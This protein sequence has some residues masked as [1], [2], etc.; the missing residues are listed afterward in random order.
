MLK[1]DIQMFAEGKVIIEADLDTKGFDKEIALLERK[2]E[3][4]K[5]T[6]VMADEDK[7]LFSKQEVMEMEAEAQKLGRQIDRLKKKQKELDE[8]G[9]NN[10]KK[11]IEDV[12]NLLKGVIT[13]VGK[14]GL[15]LFGIRSAYS[16]IRS[17][18][19][20]IASEDEQLATD[21]EYMKWV[22]AQTIKPVVEWIVNALYTALRLINAIT[23]A[24]FNFDILAG[25][26]AEAFKNSKK[27][28]GGMSSALKEAKKQL[29]GFD[30]MNVLQ[31]TSTSG[32]G[33]GGGVSLDWDM[34]DIEQKTQQFKQSIETLK[35]SWMTFGEEM[36]YSIEEMP[37]DKWT[38]GFG[39]WDL[40]IY[41][42]T[43]VVLGLWDIIT[44]LY[45]N[46]E[47]AWKVFKGIVTGDV[48]LIAEGVK[49]AVEG[50]WNIIKGVFYLLKGSFDTT[51]GVI[52]GIITNIWN[53]IQPFINKAIEGFNGLKDK[54]VNAWTTMKTKIQNLISAIKQWLTDH[55][56]E[57][58]TKI[59][60]VIGSSISGIIN[61]ILS[62]AETR[63]NGFIKSI[64]AVIS[65]INKIP[66]VELGKLS[67]VSFPRLAQG[68]IVN[69]P[70]RGVMMGSYIA[71][72]RGPEAVLPLTD[73]TL[74]KL[75]NMMPITVHVTNT[76]N[77]RVISREIQKVQN[78]NDFAF[79]S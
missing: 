8:Q 61:A 79:N 25:K 32:G 22:L 21:I 33:G 59:G 27:S 5:E 55:F 72:E 34:P 73:G 56:G 53:I 44:G 11:S 43:E 28:I 58:G 68:G 65:I 41:G 9:L 13:K 29:A 17:A 69:N 75:A 19:S 47:G 57:I 78:E 35:T 38:E 50:L 71:G 3:D 23:K 70:G 1:L 66:G 24:L 12:G 51:V 6:L 10:M 15:A 14:W 39:E 45:Q 74:Q 4:I 36:E 54:V 67:T 40:A 37:F 42:V 16:L 76:M 48:D 2:L 46:F 63:I 52:K 20:T 77:G 18:M 49:E 26:S 7:S 62:F 64:N 60:N 31:D 30:E